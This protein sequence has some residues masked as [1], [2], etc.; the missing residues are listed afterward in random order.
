MRTLAS[1]VGVLLCGALAACQKKAVVVAPPPPPPPAPAPVHR[2]RVARKVRPPVPTPPAQAAT[3]TT[4]PVGEFVDASERPALLA[5]ID[6]NLREASTRLPAMRASL[7][8]EN[9]RQIE[10]LMA[11]AQDARSK[12]MLL[13]ARRLSARALALTQ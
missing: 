10:A 5:E 3:T 9:I 7:T 12:N 13:T 8:L 1:A 6:S 4:M 11:Q 2:K